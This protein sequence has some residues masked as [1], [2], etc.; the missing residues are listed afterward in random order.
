VPKKTYEAVM[1]DMEMRALG[2][3]PE[4]GGDIQFRF[5]FGGVLGYTRGRP[6]LILWGD[7]VG[8][9]LP[10]DAQTELR[11]LGKQYADYSAETPGGPQYIAI[12]AQIVKDEAKFSPWLARSL[13]HVHAIPAKKSAGKSGKSTTGANRTRTPKPR[14]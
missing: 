9:K 12:P 10:K 1:R 8:L 11:E 2:L 7:T 6:F 3:G 14:A 13:K 4:L 5:M